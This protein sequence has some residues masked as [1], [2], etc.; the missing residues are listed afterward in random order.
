V[1]YFIVKEYQRYDQHIRT[2]EIP[3]TSDFRTR[4]P[5]DAK[6]IA[7]LYS[8][9]HCEMDWLIDIRARGFYQS[10]PTISRD[11]K[12]QA[13]ANIDGYYLELEQIDLDLRDIF[14]AE[15]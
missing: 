1:G 3:A 9:M 4:F 6:E 8:N 14:E 12:K 13:Y 11:M 15:F 10:I 7:E 5:K 2:S